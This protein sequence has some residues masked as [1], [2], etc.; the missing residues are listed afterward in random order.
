[1]AVELLVALLHTP[2]MP[3]RRLPPRPGREDEGPRQGREH[4]PLAWGRGVRVHAIIAAVILPSPDPGV[5]RL[6]HH[7]DARR[8]RLVVRKT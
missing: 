7:D 2:W 6:L 3:T 5:A 8:P 4:S 1:M